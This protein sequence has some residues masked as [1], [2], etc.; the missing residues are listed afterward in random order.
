MTWDEFQA[1]TGFE[2]L[3]FDLTKQSFA[4]LRRSKFADQT[5]SAFAFNCHSYYGDC[6][7]S[8]GVNPGFEDDE[9][10]IRFYPPDWEHECMEVDVPEIGAIWR[11]RY[12]PVQRR[13]EELMKSKNDFGNGFLTSLRRVMVRLELEG[14]IPTLNPGGEVWTL[15]TEIDAN[16]K[17]EEQL[18]E[19][20]RREM[21]RG[22]KKVLTPRKKRP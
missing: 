1:E 16:T 17:K 18:L 3:V 15:V 10:T 20:M 7:L 4:I 12:Q 8:F 21:N 2:E 19:K 13:Y 14:V 22:Q 5:F 6:S 9:E 11:E